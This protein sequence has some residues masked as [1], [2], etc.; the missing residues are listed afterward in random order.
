MA[1][2]TYKGEGDGSTSNA[3]T[4]HT[5]QQLLNTM[6]GMGGASAGGATA[7][8]AGKADKERLKN[9]KNQSKADK[10]DI[11]VT[12]E[13]T[14]T[15]KE[16]TKTT[17]SWTKAMGAA[18][19]A[20]A[21]SLVGGIASAVT[22]TAAELMKGSTNLSS[23]TAHIAGNIPFLKEVGAGAQALVAGFEGHMDTFRE[24]S[25]IGAT[26]GK[27]LMQFTDNA[28]QAGISVDALTKVVKTNAGAFAVGFGSVNKGTQQYSKFLGELK[29]DHRATYD[30]MGMKL[31]EQAELAAEYFALDMAQGRQ[32][33]RQEGEL[34]KGAH[35]YILELD[36]LSKLTGMS[37]KEA[38][39]ALRASQED[40]RMKGIYRSMED[41]T[42]QFTSGMLE[43]FGASGGKGLQRVLEEVMV[44]GG[45]AI[46]TEAKQLAATIP[47][48]Q[49]WGKFMNEATK[50]GRTM[51]ESEK[52]KAKTMLDSAIKNAQGQMD[53]NGAHISRIT[54]AGNPIY[55]QLIEMASMSTKGVE[56]WEAAGIEQEKLKKKP[57]EDVGALGAQTVLMN[58]ALAAQ[59]A[60][61]DKA[62]PIVEAGYG[63]VTDWIKTDGTKLIEDSVNK[64]AGYAEKFVKVFT[65][66]TASGKTKME[67]AWEVAKAVT[68]DIVGRLKAFLGLGGAGDAQYTAAAKE[69]VGVNDKIAAIKDKIA[70]GNLS[71]E[72][73]AKYTAELA[74][75]Q[76]RAEG[77]NATIA[78]GKAK[79]ESGGTGWFS[80]L[81]TSE[82]WGLA[83]GAV[84]VAAA[85]VAAAFFFGPVV[86]AAMAAVGSLLVTGTMIV[87]GIAAAVWLVADA[88]QGLA[89]GLHRMGELDLDKMKD[90]PTF[91]SGIAGPIA[92]LA[93]GS[94]VA[95]LGSG[96]LKS[97]ADG[98]KEFGDIKV[99]E[100]TKA[101]PALESLYKGV[102]AFTGDSLLDKAGKSIAGFFGFGGDSNGMADIAEG[103]KAFKDV[104]VAGLEGIGKGLE[105]ITEFVNTMGSADIDKTSDQITK[106][107]KNLKEYQ[108]TTANMSTD[109]SANLSASM[110]GVVKD[111]G[112]STDQLNS[113]MQ[114]LIELVQA[115]NKIEAKQLKALEER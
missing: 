6:K 18:A 96:G 33:L 68:T 97:L 25:S 40:P 100:L 64:L 5:L 34:S 65:D 105:G 98:I 37:R 35:A 51:T 22:G 62:M 11:K 102:S 76:T 19:A 24:M 74:V 8:L 38:A 78:E 43:T 54:M 59:K 39:A 84:A 12:K 114:T 1:N 26:T 60:M 82:K 14:K 44:T 9:S 72:E 86:M 46:S 20:A 30:N 4:E 53:A 79:K 112:A 41:G 21:G 49:E 73:L 109:M 29:K 36:K 90:L 87:V 108:K 75:L 92:K 113:S 110:K 23:Y 88:I 45:A 77:L 70:K 63:A 104:D 58:A 115:G 83:L 89:N 57:G 3:A 106:L 55:Q 95:K 80:D 67:G 69:L 16:A 101:G 48:I 103:L 52:K 10:E 27:N 61:A 2:V 71:P 50:N 94:I 85:A 107:I 56:A 81:H 93:G 47:E 28:V 99:N 15:T 111:S 13:G 31:D 32:K 7:S 42:K 66:S 91:L 17:K